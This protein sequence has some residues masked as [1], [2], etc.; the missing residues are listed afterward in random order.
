MNCCV[1]RRCSSRLQLLW[2]W[3]R[4]VATALIGPLASELPDAAGAAIKRQKQKQT[5]TQEN[6]KTFKSPKLKSLKRP[7]R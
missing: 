6:T 4:A 5:K 7:L 2:P 3:C 1:G